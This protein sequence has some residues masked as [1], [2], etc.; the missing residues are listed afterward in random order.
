MN[1]KILFLI[2]VYYTVIGLVFGLG[3]EVFSGNTGYNYTNPLNSTEIQAGEVD[4]GGL[5]GTGISFSRW[6]SLV[7]TGIGLPKDTPY[8]FAFI[9]ASWQVIVLILSVGFII[10]S[11]WNG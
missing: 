1:L 11:I 8:W 5:F 3:G 10:S 2:L 7:F 9:F 6:L 4:T